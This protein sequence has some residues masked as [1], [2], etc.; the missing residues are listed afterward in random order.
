MANLLMEY[1]TQ[2]VFPMKKLFHTIFQKK[3]ADSQRTPGVPLQTFI[4][5]KYA[6]ALK[7][8][9]QRSDIKLIAQAKRKVKNPFLIHS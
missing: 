2:N 5:P 8:Q 6:T 3:I 4:E 7:E 9:L 1:Q